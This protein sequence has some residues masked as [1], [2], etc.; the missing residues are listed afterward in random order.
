ML[1]D[2]LVLYRPM[3]LSPSRLRFLWIAAF[4]SVLLAGGCASLSNT[5]SRPILDD[6]QNSIRLE[7]RVDDSQAT[8]P[9]GFEHPVNMEEEDLFRILQSIRILDPPS[10]LSKLILKAKPT[11]EWAFI[12]KEARFFA[13]PLAE[14]LRMA[15]PDERVV[16]FLKHKRSAFKGTISSGIVFI[17]DQRLHFILARHRLGNQPGRPDISVDGNPFPGSSDQSYYVVPGRFQK[18]IEDT[19]APGGGENLFPKRWIAIEYVA[20]LNAPPEPL[21][22]E[23]APGEPRQA[24]PE[25]SIEE[26]LETL[27]RL[28]EKG[29][30]TEEEY[31]NKKQELLKSF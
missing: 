6:N 2:T 17:K 4:L 13:K 28:N 5:R 31:S 1:F 25:L 12:E 20:L 14:A 11:S 15:T 21:N 30:I 27:K 10:F 22:P 18:L 19:T 16:F 8:L 29:L 3:K 9:L 7:S 24:L 23:P 26:K